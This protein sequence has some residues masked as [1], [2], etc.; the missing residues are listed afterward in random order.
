[1]PQNAFTKNTRYPEIS[2]W[3]MTLESPKTK[4]YD[5]DWP[6]LRGDYAVGDPECHVAVATL[7]S[8]LHVEGAAISGPC[9]TEN[10][11]IEKI[12]ANVISNSNIRILLICGIESRGHLPGNTIIALHKNGIDEAGRIIGSSGA[13]PFIQNISPEAIRRFQDQVEVVDRIGLV[14]EEE[15][16]R[17]IEE[18]DGRAEPYPDEPFLIVKRRAKRPSVT[19]GKGDLFLGSGVVIDTSCGQVME[20]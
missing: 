6:P 18:Y 2:R 9:K 4:H 3:S 16:E 20:E 17:L 15:I 1:M 8:Q 5:D 11:G 19:S 10:L 14:D 12:V 13:I 7:A